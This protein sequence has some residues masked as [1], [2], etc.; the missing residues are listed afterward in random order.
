MKCIEHILL[1]LETVPWHVLYRA[2]LGFTCLAVFTR[3]RSRDESDWCLGVALLIMMVSLR[4]VPIF[5]RKVLRFSV[6]AQQ[7]WITRRTLAK[8]YDSYQWRKL[9]GFGIGLASYILASKEASTARVTLAVGC[10]AA[11]LAG[12][13]RWQ[14]IARHVEASGLAIGREYSRLS[15][16]E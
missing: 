1:K 7:A 2:A 4:V 9:F 10:L 8:K 3:F 15:S 14:A 13:I 6:Q 5:G 16:F 12:E 11:G